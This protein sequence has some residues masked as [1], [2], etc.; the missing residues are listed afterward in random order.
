MDSK[1]SFKTITLGSTDYKK[2]KQLYNLA[3]PDNERTPLW[4]LMSRSLGKSIDFLAI[5]DKNIFVGF[6]YLVTKG[7]LTFVFYLAIDQTQR[8]KGYGSRVLKSIIELKPSNRIALNIEA[9]DETAENY[10][11]RVNR[12]R[13]YMNNGLKP[14]NMDT[15]E[16]GVVYE[17]LSYGEG[18]LQKS[19][20]LNLMKHFAT[21]LFAPFIGNTIKFL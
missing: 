10:T 17:M 2:M 15:K 3:F 16:S 12:K 7:D 19:E 18:G 20:Y 6:C 13:F 11:Q 8:G 21:P 5:Y 9:I 14:A 4:I 1:L